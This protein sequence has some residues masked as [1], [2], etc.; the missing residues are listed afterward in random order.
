MGQ[1]VWDNTQFCLIEFIPF[2]KICSIHK[3]KSYT[4]R[5]DRF[6]LINISS[7]LPIY[8]W[9]PP[10]TSLSVAALAETDSCAPGHPQPNRFQHSI[11][12][13]VLSSTS[14]SVAKAKNSWKDLFDSR[15]QLVTSLYEVLRERATKGSSLVPS[16]MPASLST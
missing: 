9:D 10:E 11:S 8:G 1:N 4:A 7:V 5:V 13:E 16:S 6:Q 12:K 14:S 2:G 3:N 15:P